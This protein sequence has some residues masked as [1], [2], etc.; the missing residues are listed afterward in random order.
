M[1]IRVA[2]TGAAG[3]MG[4]TVCRAVEEAEG[5]ELVARLDVGDTIGAETLNGADVAV[6]FTVPSVT[7]ANVHALIDAGVDV[8]V[9]TTGWDEE[10]Y[11]RV[12]EHLARPEASGRSVLIAPNF[13]LSAVL[14]MAMAAKA[15]PYFESAEVIELHHPGKVD[16]PSGTALATAWRIGDARAEAGLGPVPDATQTDPDG[17]RGAVVN[18]VHVHA[19]R[20]RGLT[21]H[22]EI[23]LGNPGEQLTIRTDCFDRASFMPGVVLAVREVGAR[24]GLTIGLDAVMDL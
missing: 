6:D 24:P 13:S 8:V 19:V 23:V 7:E 9:G 10:S 3:R 1:T 20:L 14:A 5:L 16:A 22:E 12:R 15:A 2:V 17:S 4:S 21:A 11:A 18:G